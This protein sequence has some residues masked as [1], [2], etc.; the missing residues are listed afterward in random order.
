[1]TPAE[2]IQLKAFARIDGA[3][4][5][6][7]W[8]TGFVCYVAGLTNQMLGLLAIVLLLSSPLFVAKRLKM[9]R[10]MALGG[11]ISFSRG[12]AYV[13]LVFFYASLLLALAVYAYFAFLDHGYV[14]QTL[15]NTMSNPEMMQLLEQYQMDDMLNQTINEMSSVR[16]IDIALNMLASN[17][18]IGL[19]VGMP[20]AAV[21]KSKSQKD[22]SSQL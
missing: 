4:L 17:L 15:R 22:K 20:V 13:V 8:L 1:M 5:A 12:W 7:W 6:L 16:P 9:F 18:I 21:L 2:Y 10:D 11:A 3:L 19:V 14:I